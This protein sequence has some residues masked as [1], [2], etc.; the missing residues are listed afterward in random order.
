MGWRSS[1]SSQC[2]FG[3]SYGE[4]RTGDSKKRSVMV[5]VYQRAVA[6]AGGGADREYAAHSRVGLVRRAMDAGLWVLA[7]ADGTAVI[8]LAAD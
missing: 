2:C 3:Y 8:G 5:A 7:V 6:R 4:F 1:S